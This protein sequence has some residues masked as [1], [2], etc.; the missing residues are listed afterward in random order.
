[1]TI[2]MTKDDGRLNVTAS[3]SSCNFIKDSYY[4]CR[5]RNNDHP[6]KCQHIFHF[7]QT[8]QLL[9]TENVGNCQVYLDTVGKAVNKIDYGQTEVKN[10]K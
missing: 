6:E 2:T 10:D 8:C 3:K 7:Y 5:I 4:G 9:C 1:M